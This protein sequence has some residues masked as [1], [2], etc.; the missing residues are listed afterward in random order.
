M[1]LSRSQ[2]SLW[3]YGQAAVRIEN[4]TS[5]ADKLG[6]TAAR[7]FPKPRSASVLLEALFDASQSLAGRPSPRRAIVVVNIEQGDEQ[8]RR[9]PPQV[10][11]SL[12]FSRSQLWLVSVQKGQLAA[13]KR[14]LALNALV[15]N[16]GGRREFIVA[17]SAIEGY[18]RQYAAALTSQYEITYRRPSRSAKIVQT[19]V[20]RE[21]ARVIA[22]LAAPQ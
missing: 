14:D 1:I 9:E 17:A 15:R 8:S 20:R 2:L 22:G 3:E 13:E 10:N 12:I 6:R 18:M 21:G 4:F 7:L 19:G 16:A 5:D 11:E